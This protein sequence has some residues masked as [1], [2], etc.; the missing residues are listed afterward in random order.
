[1]TRPDSRSGARRPW[2]LLGLIAAVLLGLGALYF[3]YQFLTDYE[4]LEKGQLLSYTTGKIYKVRF[5]GGL[6]L[7]VA[8]ELP[9]WQYKDLLNAYVLTGVAFVAL[10][11]AVLLRTVSGHGAGSASLRLF[12]V[13]FVGISCLVADEVLGLHESIG[14]NMQFLLGLPGVH[15]PDDVLT[16]LMGIPVAA[17]LVYFRST[18]LASRRAVIAFAAAGLGFLLA[19]V[20]DVL[21]LPIEEGLEVVVSA[22]LL[23]GVF[24]LGLHY[25]RAG[26][27]ASM[28]NSRSRR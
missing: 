19:A 9:P 25:L 2:R 26:D 17:F 10:T 28:S 3:A 20:S 24:F 5:G 16:V 27:Q 21:A 18:L 1:M 7:Y 8:P 6:T 11:F 13:M 22:C 12:L 4:V 23:V 15:R 14:H